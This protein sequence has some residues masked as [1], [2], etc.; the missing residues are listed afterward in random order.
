[1]LGDN[2]YGRSTEGGDCSECRAVRRQQGSKLGTCGSVPSTMSRTPDPTRIVHVEPSR[3]DEAMS[4][5]L[6][7]GPAAAARFVEQARASRVALEHLWCSTDAQGR[8]RAAV[9]AVPSPGRASMLLAT[10]ARDAD[11]AHQLGPLIAAAIAGSAPF[12]DIAQALIEPARVHD[13]TAFEVGGLTRMADLEYLERGLPRAGIIETPPTPSGWT[14]EPAGTPVQL[15]GNEVEAIPADTREELVTALEQTYLDTLDCPG[16]AGMRATK[17][18]LVGHFGSG[19]RPRHWLVARQT[20]SSEVA[21]SSPAP[22]PRQDGPQQDNQQV[23]ALPP[24]VSQTD[25][26]RGPVQ[27]VCLLNVTPDGSGAELVYLGLAPAARGHGIAQALL[28]HGL[29]ACSRSR[30]TSVSLAVDAR[31]VFARRLY[32]RNGFRRVST[33]VA[34]VCKTHDASHAR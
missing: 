8:Y 13:I 11:D 32:E 19:A 25:G 16:L 31:N 12:A 18:V 33:R 28:A 27:G 29:H 22:L 5:L 26:R 15:A 21:D 10:R 6:G 9:L 1:M 20:S 24:R 2:P 4:A 34:L 23:D 3:L 30:C 14:I 7:A 17:D